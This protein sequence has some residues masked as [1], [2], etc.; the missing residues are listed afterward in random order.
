MIIF[1]NDTSN[2]TVIPPSK[3]LIVTPYLGFK[4]IFN[5][6]WTVMVDLNKY[7]YSII[8]IYIYARLN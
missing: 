2:L 3:E 7:L 5:C 8:Y 6:P 1:E 4:Y